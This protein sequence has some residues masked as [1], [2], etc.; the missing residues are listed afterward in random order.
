LSAAARPYVVA[1]LEDSLGLVHQSVDPGSVPAEL[2][3]DLA[4]A[5]RGSPEAATPTPALEEAILRFLA[6]VEAETL[7]RSGLFV[8]KARWPHNV[9][10]AACITH[11]VDNVSR[12]MTHLLKRAGRFSFADVTLALLGLRSLYNNIDLITDLEAR[13]GLRSSFYFMSKNYDLN[14]L[15][16]TARRLAGSGWEVGL[17]GDFGTYD[18]AEAMEDAVNRL[19][20]AFG[21]RPVG[22]REHFL[23]FDYDKTWEIAQTSGFIYDSTVGNR[24]HLGFRLGLCTPFHPPDSGWNQMKVVE[25]PLVL[26][27]TTLWGY[28]GRSESEGEKD[29]L[30]LLE[31]VNKVNGLMTLLWHQESLR[32]KGGRIY[33]RLL[34][35]LAAGDCYAATGEKMA[36]WWI[37]RGRPLVSDGANFQT[38]N[39]PA[40]MVLSFKSTEEKALVVEGGILNTR[41]DGQTVTASGGPLRVKVV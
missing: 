27:D 15:T 28:L 23:Q 39:A 3:D 22:L 35:S 4:M 5:L 19:S 17:H 1:F 6:A 33:P 18:S 41:A 24:D 26:M 12:P 21:T 32:M 2:V 29:F 14:R 16:R 31:Q 36:R 10:F 30:S 25:L 34:A 38:D 13:R 37:E 8:R 40:G 9:R 11:D 20:S 7:E